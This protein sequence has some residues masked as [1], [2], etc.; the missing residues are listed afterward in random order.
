MRIFHK[1]KLELGRIMFMVDDIYVDDVKIKSSF[2]PVLINQ[3]SADKE[4]LAFAAELDKF[5][6]KRDFYSMFSLFLIL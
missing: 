5:T 1:K 3:P 4:R 6:F 2:R